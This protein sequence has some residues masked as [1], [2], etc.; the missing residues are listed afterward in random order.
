MKKN[1]IIVFLTKIIIFGNA[2]PQL[3]D[4]LQI[5]LISVVKYV[6]NCNRLNPK[7][8]CECLKYIFQEISNESFKIFL[9]KWNFQNH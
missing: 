8:N 2:F 9:K 3:Y 7:T 1:E 6:Y 4:L 5:E